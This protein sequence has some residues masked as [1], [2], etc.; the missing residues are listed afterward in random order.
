M[1]IKIIINFIGN[2]FSSLIA[3]DSTVPGA[4]G[5]DVDE[6]DVC[7][8]NFTPL[9]TSESCAGTT[10]SLFS[11]DADDGHHGLTRFIVLVPVQCMW[12]IVQA[13]YVG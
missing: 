13:R 5:D 2:I 7:A 11:D 3:I 10:S 8:L 4:A 1:V 9:A 6:C 12:Y